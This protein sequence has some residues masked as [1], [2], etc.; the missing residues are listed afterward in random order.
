[1]EDLSRDCGPGK[2]CP[3]YQAGKFPQMCCFLKKQRAEW[4][5]AMLMSVAIMI[6]T[7]AIVVGL[8]YASTN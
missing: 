5:L 8:G 7:A 1:V 3:A 6:L 2:V 4:R